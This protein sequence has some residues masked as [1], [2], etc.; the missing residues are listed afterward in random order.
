MNKEK[1][2]YLNLSTN[3]KDISLGFSNSWLSKFA[4]EFESVDLISLNKSSNNQTEFKNVNIFG[5]EE[6]ENLSKIDK[7]IKLKNLVKGLTQKNDYAICFSHMSPLLSIIA[8]WYNKNKKTISILWYTHPMPKEL[9]KKIVL[10]ISLFFNNQI[11]TASESSFPYFSKK[12]NVIG[13]AIDYDAFLN[14]KTNISNN[15]F[16]I[17]SRISKSKNLE[18]SIDCFLKSKFNQNSITVIGDVVTDADIEY[19]A[20]LT[21]K[22]R[23][24]NNVVFKGMIPH[25]ELPNVLKSYSYHINSTPPGFYD[26]SVLET[27]AAGIYNFYLNADYDKHFDPNSI[28]Y[29]KFLSEHNSL[30]E[31]LN[32]VYEMNENKILEIISFA[33]NSVSKE[34]IN[35]ISDRVLS[36][37]EN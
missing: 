11:V 8:N 15:D 22:Y 33:Q 14:K 18:L 28:K 2:L 37:V 30:T 29:T 25:K 24:K 26:K 35:T 21:E 9:I 34:T 27:L 12:V 1:L 5:I 19:K 7:F 4:D 23:T 31:L 13:H 32:S 3:E 6:S 10:Y 17:L 16:V 20:Y 36:T